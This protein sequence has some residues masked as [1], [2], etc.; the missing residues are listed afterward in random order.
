VKNEEL[1]EAHQMKSNDQ[2]CLTISPEMTPG[3][4]TLK[5]EF[6]WD[7]K[8]VKID[9]VYAMRQVRIANNELG[10][11]VLILGCAIAFMVGLLAAKE[12]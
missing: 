5:T 4:Y 8:T 10:Y 3:T 9:D 6:H 1:K 11:G 2:F 7:G 12:V